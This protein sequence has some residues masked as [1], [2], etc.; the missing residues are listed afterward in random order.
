MNA[1]PRVLVSVPELAAALAAGETVHVLDV[2][3]SL[4]APDGREAYGAGHLPGAVYVSLE[5]ELSRHGE[6]ADGRHPVPHLAELEAAAR[7]WGLRN[8]QPV[9]VYDDGP[10]LA[11]A[12]A[13]WLLRWA[14]VE[15]V[16]LLDGGLAAWRAAGRALE[17]GVADVEPGDVTL[18]GGH[19][20]TI[21]DD[22]AAAW[23]SRGVLLDA[24]AGERYRGEVEPI[25]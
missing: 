10:G 2:R 7:R 21:D 20:P 19:L 8:G 23:P 24:R 11:A 9:I 12:R 25:D 4:A 16:T 5:D 15:D 18:S 22:E 1:T 13:W 17:E 14:G 6:P 3:W